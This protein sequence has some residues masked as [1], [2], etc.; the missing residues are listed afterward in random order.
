MT[1]K[2]ANLYLQIHSGD[3]DGPTNLEEYDQ[4][5]SAWVPVGTASQPEMIAADEGAEDLEGIEEEVG[6]AVE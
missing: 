6:G 5:V 3:P 4:A 1:G 2:H